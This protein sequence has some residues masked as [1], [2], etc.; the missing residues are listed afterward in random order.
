MVNFFAFSATEDPQS[1]VKWP[2]LRQF[3]N[4]VKVFLASFNVAEGWN[5]K[6]SEQASVH[7]YKITNSD[8]L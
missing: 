4:S 8:F 2:D 6:K 5:F 7:H 3:I 1:F